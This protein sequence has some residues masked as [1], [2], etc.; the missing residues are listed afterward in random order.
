[1]LRP[2]REALVHESGSNHGED[3]DETLLIHG[4]LA[5]PNKL[6]APRIDKANDTVK[7]L[8]VSLQRTHETTRS[9]FRV[10]VRVGRYVASALVSSR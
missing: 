6:P 9:N 4:Q 1:M 3:E 5:F 10:L 2:R 7:V 8:H